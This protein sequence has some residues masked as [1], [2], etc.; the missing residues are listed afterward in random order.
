[1]FAD[2]SYELEKVLQ[3]SQNGNMSMKNGDTSELGSGC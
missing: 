3:G 1:M 2:S